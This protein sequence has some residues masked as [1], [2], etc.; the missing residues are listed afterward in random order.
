MARL[1]TTP[2]LLMALLPSPAAAQSWGAF[3]AQSSRCMRGGSRADCRMALEQ[4]H[5]LKNW[6]EQRKLWRC[7]TALLA[8]E[9]GMIASA[10]NAPAAVDATQPVDVEVRRDLQVSCGR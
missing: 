3:D 6:A 4:S 7:Y 10:L 1:L 8:A 9:A 2:L 5:A